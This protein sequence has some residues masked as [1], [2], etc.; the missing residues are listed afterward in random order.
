M[1]FPVEPL[2]VREIGDR[3]L[4]IYKWDGLT[5]S[6]HP[7]VW[8]NVELF[9]RQ[10]RKIWTVNGMEKSRFWDNKIDAFV[11][12]RIKNGRLQLTSFSGNSYDLDLNTGEVTHYA[13]HK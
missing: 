2:E 12:T 5:D 1:N 3:F 9:D 8:E 11:G 6:S 13:F 10:G 4:V 7:R